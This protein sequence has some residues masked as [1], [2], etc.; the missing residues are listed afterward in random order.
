MDEIAWLYFKQ[1]ERRLRSKCE[2]IEDSVQLVQER[3]YEGN[4][5]YQYRAMFKCQKTF[6]TRKVWLDRLA[7][8]VSPS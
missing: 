6:R 8:V 1:L 4:T 7:K 5:I 2:L 3:V